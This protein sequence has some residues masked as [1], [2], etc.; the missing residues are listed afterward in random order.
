MT[1]SR[2]RFDFVVVAPA[3]SGTTMLVRALDS[4]PDICCHGEVLGRH[5]VWAFSQKARQPVMPKS[6]HM[7]QAEYWQSLLNLR[8]KDHVAFYREC[9][10]SPKITQ[11]AVGFKFLYPQMLDLHF[12]DVVEQICADTS[13][14]I[15]YLRRRDDFGR[16]L[17]E[18][19]Y[20]DAFARK[21]AAPAAAAGQGVTIDLD[22]FVQAVRNHEAALRRVQ[23]W[24]EGHRSITVYYEDLVH[25][26]DRTLA[27]L[28]EFLGVEVRGL[29]YR[30][31]KASGDRPETM[32]VNFREVADRA[33]EP[34]Y[35]PYLAHSD[36][37]NPSSTPGT[38]IRDEV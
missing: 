21:N 4:H 7:S 1:G 16:Y 20:L 9:L 29:E 24:L 27:G 30:T 18:R 11:R 36:V 2:N 6:A 23:K 38:R 15:I 34:K 35:A 12:A 28:L 25:N 14:G 3:R 26:K 10:F 31:E 17:S 8:E 5:R 22:H 13:V 32:I 37:L 19:L 33:S